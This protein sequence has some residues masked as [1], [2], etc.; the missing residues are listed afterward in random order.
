M[1]EEI[2]NLREQITAMK[3]EEKILKSNLAG[4]KATTSTQDLRSNLITIEREKD[5]MFHRLKLLR[6]GDVK[7]V[8]PQEKAELDKAWKEWSR[9]V[10]SRKKICMDVWDYIT[11]ELPEGKTKEELW[12]SNLSGRT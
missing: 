5:E 9:N 8:S 4:L 6:V 3:S 1:D 2:A 12:V 11:E 10:A 7:P